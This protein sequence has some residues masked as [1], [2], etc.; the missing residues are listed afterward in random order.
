MTIVFVAIL[1]IA[2]AIYSIAMH[3][4]KEGFAAFVCLAIAL[5]SIS[6]VVSF[7]LGLVLRNSTKEEYLVLK[8]ERQTIESVLEHGSQSE[9]IALASQIID[10]NS[11]ITRAKYRANLPIAYEY[12]SNS[13]DW[14][15]LTSIQW[16]E[17]GEK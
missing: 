3:Y 1:I 17:S 13:C 16:K 6:I 12:M 5:V 7:T 9:R 15:A 4:G 2:I 8:E 10:Y 14:N 11:R